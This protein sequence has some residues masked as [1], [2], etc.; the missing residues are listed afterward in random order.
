MQKQAEKRPLKSGWATP[1]EKS[2]V[3]MGR[4]EGGKETS[5]MLTIVPLAPL[6]VDDVVKSMYPPL[7]PKLLDAR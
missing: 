2:G 4:K 6:R 5:K 7:D 1:P 3:T